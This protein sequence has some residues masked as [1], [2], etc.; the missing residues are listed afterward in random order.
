MG[1][2][3]PFR[4][5]QHGDIEGCNRAWIFTLNNYTEADVTEIQSW[6]QNDI[7]AVS[8]GKE[9]GKSG[10]PHL[11]GAITWRAP[12][13]FAAMKK[14]L[15]RAWLAKAYGLRTGLKYAAKEGNIV[16]QFDN[17]CQ[18]KRKDSERAWESAIA[19]KTLRDF[20]MEEP[21]GY[22]T[23]RSFEAVRMAAMRRVLP[24]EG[25]KVIWVWGPSE[26]GKSS[27]AL[28]RG[29]HFLDKDERFA[30]DYDGQ[31][32]IVMD[33]L[34]PDEY[35]LKVLFRMWDRYPYM[36]SIKGTRCPAMWHTVYVT[37]WMSP[38]QFWDEIP[39]KGDEPKKQFTRRITQVIDMSAY[40]ELEL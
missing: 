29:A 27:F 13:R 6:N 4:L 30:A 11:Q 14:I 7:L 28:E 12:K 32:I 20:V 33:E 31:E 21:V 39:R 2:T 19:G 25:I 18:G 37:T 8:I 1:K 16:M 35:P 15:P 10:T 3:N 36:V 22:G 34:R 23:I 9:V 26:C 24:P 40:N 38:D 5:K 17:G